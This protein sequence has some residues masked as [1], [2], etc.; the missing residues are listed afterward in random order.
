VS[1]ISAQDIE[2]ILPNKN[3]SHTMTPEEK[4]LMKTYQRDFQETDPPTGEVRNIAE[5]EPM[6]TV[7]IAYVNGF[8]VPY[9]LIADISN[10]SHVTILADA[11][12]H[13]YISNQLSNNGVNMSNCSFIDHQTDRW[14]TRDYSPWCI[15]VDNQEVALVDFEY[16]RPDRPNDDATPSVVAAN[17]GV[18]YY[19]MAVVHTGGNYMTDGYGVSAST[20]LVY[21]ENTIS[22]AQLNQKMEDYLG[23]TTYHTLSDPMD[24]YIEHIDCWGKY[25]DVDKILITEVPVSDYRYDDFEACADYF[26]NQNCS[27]GYPYN[28]YRVKA[29]DDYYDDKNPYTNSLIFN[30]KVFVPQTSSIWDDDALAVYEEAM[31]GYDI[32]GVYASGASWYNTDA[33]HCRTHGF[34]D[35]DML[36]IKHFPVYGIHEQS[37][38]F[39]ITAD[40]YS[41]A[42]NSLANGFPKL[43]YKIDDSTYHSVVMTLSGTNTYSAQIPS[44][45]GEH[46]ISYYIEAQ[47]E[48]GRKQKNRIMGDADPYTFTSRNYEVSVEK[49]K[50]E[51]E[52]KL[53]PNPNS[54]RFYL[55]FNFVEPQQVTIEIQNLSGQIIY[56]EQKNINTFAEVAYINLT[57]ISTGVYIVNTKTQT[58][59]FVSKL[60]IR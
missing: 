33:L 47:D 43:H 60:I 34:A 42:G 11:S 25:L 18:D 44:Y 38:P 5:W 48:T 1:F 16:N 21:D 19:G 8:G 49:I 7:F 31:P 50:I 15:A 23:I 14:W 56:S 9:S 36:F 26:A 45:Y 37:E 46:I 28:V 13:S 57:N 27:F 17:L 22:N 6:E 58:E 54:G 2:N 41:Y 40:V 52:V 29:Y 51:N 39:E 3:A 53:Y 35:R 12:D 59:T 10:Y 30:G 4:E 32:I 24:D 20:T 55:Q